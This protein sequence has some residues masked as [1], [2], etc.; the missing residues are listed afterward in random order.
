MYYFILFIIFIILLDLKIVYV[1]TNVT[2]ERNG[3]KN[4]VINFFISHREYIYSFFC[5]SFEGDRL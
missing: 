1:T 5:T 2:V 3:R 4:Q